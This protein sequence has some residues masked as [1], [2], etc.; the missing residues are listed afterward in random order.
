MHGS[1]V[2]AELLLADD[3]MIMMV[4]VVVVVVVVM[5]MTMGDDDDG[6]GDDDGDAALVRKAHDG[7]GDDDEGGPADQTMRR[8]WC[9]PGGLPSLL[10]VTTL[11][12]PHQDHRCCWCRHDA[13]DHTNCHGYH[14]HHRRCTNH[15]AAGCYLPTPPGLRRSEVNPSDH[16]LLTCLTRSPTYRPDGDG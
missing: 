1:V 10:P 2:S 13:A 15:H 9:L 6:D 4:V 3:D 11:W 7:G 5:M 12:S 16:C 8:C 14:H